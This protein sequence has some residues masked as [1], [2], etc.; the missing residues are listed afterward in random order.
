MEPCTGIGMITI[1]VRLYLVNRTFQPNEQYCYAEKVT[2]AMQEGC[3]PCGKHVRNTK[4][5]YR[6]Y[7]DGV[8]YDIKEDFAVPSEIPIKQGWE[9]QSFEDRRERVGDTQFMN[10]FS[11]FRIDEDPAKIH[12]EANKVYDD[13][14]H[15]DGR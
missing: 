9:G 7:I 14:R 6:V 8:K 15:N 1:Q 11:K 3:L 13:L 5:F 4:D 10:E 2:K 12:E